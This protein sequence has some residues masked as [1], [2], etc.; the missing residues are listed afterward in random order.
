VADV[1]DGEG[2]RL[3]RVVAVDSRRRV[4]A[5]H[6]HGEAT[7]GCGRVALP[8]DRSLHDGHKAIQLLL[9]GHRGSSQLA[10]PEEEGLLL[11]TAQYWKTTPHACRYSST[12]LHSWRCQAHVAGMVFDEQGSDEQR[13]HENV[14]I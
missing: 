12:E 3:V 6:R 5:G 8:V 1:R 7:A 14:R 9:S 4:V 10:R 13:C 11:C 2:H